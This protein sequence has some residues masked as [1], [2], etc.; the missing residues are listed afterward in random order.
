[1]GEGALCDAGGERNGFV[2][3]ELFRNHPERREPGIGRFALE[4][5]GHDVAECVEVGARAYVAL[6][7]FG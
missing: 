3:L 5:R 1:V 7:L 2:E 4:H 6:E